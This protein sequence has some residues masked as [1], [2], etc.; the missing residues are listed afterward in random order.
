MSMQCTMNGSRLPMNRPPNRPPNSA[1][2]ARER[3]QEHARQWQQPTRPLCLAACPGHQ[4]SPSFATPIWPHLTKLQQQVYVLLYYFPLHN[5]CIHLNGPPALSPIASAPSVMDKSL[6][7][8]VRERQ[9]RI[10]SSNSRGTSTCADKPL[11]A[12]SR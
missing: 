9:V 12:A 6:D 8:V 7:E 4:R 1:S 5:T 2:R 10:S 3:R 11:D